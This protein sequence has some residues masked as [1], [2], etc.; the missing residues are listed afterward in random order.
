MYTGQT[1]PKWSAQSREAP[2]RFLGHFD[3]A[4]FANLNHG[5]Q[6]TRSEF[7]QRTVQFCWKS[8]NFVEHRPILC[9]NL[10]GIYCRNLATVDVLCTIESHPK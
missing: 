10:A 6:K 7:S 3:N 1:V 9:E 4:N 8:S 5:L 2:T